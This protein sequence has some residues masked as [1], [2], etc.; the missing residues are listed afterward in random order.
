MS[1]Y[2]YA[3]EEFWQGAEWS[4][5]NSLIHGFAARKLQM[6]YVHWVVLLI[7]I[8]AAVWAVVVLIQRRRQLAQVV[9]LWT[10]PLLLVYC[11][12]AGLWWFNT[13]GFYHAMMDWSLGK[14][15]LSMLR[16]VGV[17]AIPIIGLY[18]GQPS[19]SVKSMTGKDR[20]VLHLAV[21]PIVHCL[22]TTVYMLNQN[23]VVE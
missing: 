9:P 20:V 13:L 16:S 3:G 10:V 15:L 5:L 1:T 17:A 8:I 2:S 22:L 21:F 6:V 19:A 4:G 11:V 7:F 23:F 18:L 12:L 14:R